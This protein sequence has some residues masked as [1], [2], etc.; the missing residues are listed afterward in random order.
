MMEENN[1]F[2]HNWDKFFKNGKTVILPIDHGTVIPV[3]E[4]NNPGQLIENVS[5]FVDGFVVNFGLARAFSEQLEGKGICF[6]TDVYK[7]SFKSNPDHG[8]Y[9][10]YTAED[11]LSVGSNAV[12]NMCYTNH[13]SEDRIYRECASLVSE[14]I[15]L[16]LPVIIESLPFGIGKPND[17]TL[18]NISFAVRMAAELGA[19]VIKTAFPIDANIND[20]RKIIDSSFVPVVVLG[21][22]A[23]GD[24]KALLQMVKMSMDSGASGIAVGRNVWQHENPTLMAKCLHAIVHDDASLDQALGI[25]EEPKGE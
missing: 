13:Q 7:P 23:M 5:P 2:R 22:A 1:I 19:D 16:E 3:P 17:Y 24:D 6:R 14:C 4:L 10:S 12:M 25:L 21:G 11:A 9:R 18:E 8:S 15:D 20:F